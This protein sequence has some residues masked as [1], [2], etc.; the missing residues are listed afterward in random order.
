MTAPEADI[1]YSTIRDSSETFPG[2]GEVTDDATRRFLSD[3]L[4]QSRVY[5]ARVL[6]VIPRG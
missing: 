2:R 1:R 4:E 6:T 3:L 5:I